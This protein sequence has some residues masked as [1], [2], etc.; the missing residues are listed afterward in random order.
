MAAA[1]GSRSGAP[2]RHRGGGS[3]GVASGLPG[4]AGSAE[5]ANAALLQAAD[6]AALHPL[7]FPRDDQFYYVH[8]ITTT[9]ELIR[10]RALT[11]LPIGGA[12]GPRAIVTLD[13]QLWYSAARGGR[14]E[15]RAVSVQFP[16]ALA[17]R[18]WERLGLP[19]LA[20]PSGTQAVAPTGRGRY[21][22]GNLELTRAQVYALPLDP[23]ALY[24]RLYAA[25]GSPSEV[26]TEIGDTLRN[27]PAPAAVR[28]ALYRTLAIVPGIRWVGHVTDGQGR[29]GIAVGYESGGVEDELIFDPA[30]S[31]MLEER[32]IAVTPATARRLGVRAGTV[33]SSTTYLERAATDNATAP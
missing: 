11:L 3:S 31:S 17:R 1:R 20:G 28:A 15:S 29:P 16:T 23:R 26:F 4:R 14:E 2:R 27:R 32:T 12:A 13:Q 19:P 33:T 8:S 6:A 22:I 7:P 24:A 30:S 18:L 9:S 21:L 10:R 25:G 5:G